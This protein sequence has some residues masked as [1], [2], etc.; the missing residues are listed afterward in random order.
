[1]KVSA[2]PL[3]AI[4]V[5][6]VL[7]ALVCCIPYIGNAKNLTLIG[8]AIT[9]HKVQQNF[10]CS[11]VGELDEQHTAS[12]KSYSGWP[13]VAVVQVPSVTSGCDMYAD[14]DSAGTTKMYPLAVIMNAL[15]VFAVIILIIGLW[16]RRKKK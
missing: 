11:S 13:F 16:D 15:P 4:G 3:I 2:R 14:A 5:G 8:P 12:P 9:L 10:L 1:M 6:V 7:T